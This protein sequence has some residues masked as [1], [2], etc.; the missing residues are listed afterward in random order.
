MSKPIVDLHCHPALKPYS[1]S[2]IGNMW[3]YHENKNAKDLFRDIS[4]RKLLVG[5]IVK[6]MATFTQSNLDNCYKGSNRL[7]FI[8]VYPP[9]RPFMKPRRPF[10]HK[11]TWIQRTLLRWIFGKKLK[12]HV[13]A[14][15]IQMLTGFSKDT[16]NRYLDEIH[17]A[18]H[19]HI[20][21]F[22][23]DYVEEYCYIK[24]GHLTSSTSPD[25]TIK[26]K[27]R[28]VRD[29]SE[30]LAHKDS[31]EVLGVITAEGMHALARYNKDDLFNKVSIDELSPDNRKKLEDSFKDNIKRLKD[32]Q[33]FEYP[34]FFITFSHH[35]NNLISGHAKSFADAK[36][37]VV[38]GFK[39]VFDQRLG[40]DLGITVSG[41][42]LI[43]DHLL[44]RDNGKRILIDTKHMSLNT[45]DD[46]IEI[47]NALKAQG[48]HVPIICSHTAV[49]GISTR[50]RAREIPDVNAYDKNSYVSRWDVNLT[51][52]DIIEIF[53]SDGVI[54]VCMHDGRMPGGK[55]K[56]LLK[57]NSKKLV[58]DERVKRLHAQM[59]LTN[60]FHIVKVNLVHIRGHNAG[61]AG[62]KID[63]K[64][65]WKTVCLGTDNDGIVD[66]F[67]HYS[68]AD[69]LDDFKWRIAQ[70]LKLNDADHM[71]ETRVISLPTEVPFT[72]NEMLDMMMG[73]TPEEI[74]DLIFSDNM[75]QFLEKYF[76]QDYLLGE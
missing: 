51:D 6:N 64:E 5:G 39:D 18:E 36:N 9:E 3:K 13:D 34:P 52:E 63:E 47:I 54:G 7:V 62:P 56:K 44:S 28:L 31:K 68:T 48:D 58:S 19:T 73:Y 69:K 72:S 46:F 70:A 1:N 40:M 43:K 17:D 53:D 60:I 61:N 49:N 16:A 50:Q 30:Y 29:F 20:D 59:F 35:F 45:R 57:E 76:T 23:K 11:L 32:P 2:A 10:D 65:A 74:A 66:P 75:M 25:F 12:K 4:F 22:N 15:I 27:F 41:K 21:Y 71:K 55:F 37:G 24:D 8:A 38:P 33:E 67:D 26:P 42:E 14:K